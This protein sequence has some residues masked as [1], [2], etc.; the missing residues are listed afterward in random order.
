MIR[1][2]LAA[3]ALTLPA[4]ALAA[5]PAAAPASAVTQMDHVS[6]ESVGS[7]TPIVLIPGLAT[8]RDVYRP[9]VADLARSHRVLLVQVN[10]FA[11]EGPGRNAEGGVIPGV[12]ADIS[13]YLER[14]NLGPAFVAGHSMGGVIGMVLARDHAAQVRKLMIIDSLPF[15]GSMFMPGATVETMRPLAE[16]LRTAVASGMMQRSPVGAD[17]P[18]TATMSVN[19]AGRLQVSRWS[20]A[21]NPQV[22][23]HAMYE[24]AVMDLRPDLPRI[25]QVPTTVLYATGAERAQSL[26]TGEYAGAPSIRMAPVPGSYHFIMLDQPDLFRRELQAFVADR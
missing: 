13:A 22:A 16:Q 7:G 1:L 11:G 19:P 21:A 15:I 5:Q 23:A 6:I 14:N 26:F 4:A 20:H 17:D 18:G 3:L 2:A 24:V 8:P 25:A 9:F 12:V 10:G